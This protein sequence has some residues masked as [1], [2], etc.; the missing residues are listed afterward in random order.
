MTEQETYLNSVNLKNDTDFPFLLTDVVNNVSAPLNPG[1]RVM[2]WHEDLQLIYVLTGALELQT[3]DG[4]LRLQQGEIAFINKN[5][6]HYIRQLGNVH[7]K[8]ILFPAYFLEFYTGG[9]A[10][11]LVEDVVGNAQLPLLHF[12]PELPYY[13]AMR[14]LLQQLL[15]A[16]EQRTEC[17]AYEILVHL[18]GF[19]LLLRKNIRLA[20]PAKENAVNLR[21]HKILR[22]IEAHYAEDITL[23]DLA[24]SAAISKSE[25][26]R[27]F[28]TA[29]KTTP[30]K[31]LTEFRLAK[32]AQLLKSTDSS[33]GQIAGSVGFNQ[34][35]HFGQC[36]KEKTGCSPKA[37][38][39]KQRKIKN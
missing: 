8:N 36:F 9:P 27:C 3:L 14:G 18:T 28:K 7:Y 22:Y 32:A 1:F 37:Y 13:A 25:C 16:E 5:I 24:G 39:E 15:T 38:R 33:I 2:H 12:T 21:M 4:S 30:Y 23:A 34:L 19:W 10:K 11:A 26:A 31:Y 17:Y 20:V 6:V 35:S 29:L